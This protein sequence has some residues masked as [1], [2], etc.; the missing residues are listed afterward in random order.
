MKR[1]FVETTIKRRMITFRENGNRFTYRIAGIALHNGRMLFQRAD[2]SPVQFWFLPGGRAEL[3]ETSI[4]T[5]MR[6]IQ[7]ELGVEVIIERLLYVV[8]NFFEYPHNP[9][10]EIGFY[11]LISFPPDS[12]LYSQPG[13]FERYDELDRLNV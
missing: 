10:H 9:H 12:Y 7:E 4:E 3:H 11:F 13:P 8:E 2:D 5:L 6:E 1:N